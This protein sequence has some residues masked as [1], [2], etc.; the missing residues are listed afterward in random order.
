MGSF[1]RFPGEERQSFR[2][3]VKHFSGIPLV[4]PFGLA[5][6]FL[7]NVFFNF[8]EALDT[9]VETPKSFVNAS[10]D[11]VVPVSGPV[12]D[13]VDG[14]S[15]YSVLSDQITDT[16]M[17]FEVVVGQFFLDGRQPCLLVDYHIVYANCYF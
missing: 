11:A 17:S 15:G 8:G 12:E 3:E 1:G 14:R 2:V 9:V 6:Q 7:F 13:L 4:V 10:V 16:D 5:F